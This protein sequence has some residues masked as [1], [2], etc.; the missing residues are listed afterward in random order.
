MNGL[1]NCSIVSNSAVDRRG[2]G[3]ARAPLKFGGLEKR[4]EKEICR[5][6]I[7]VRSRFKKDF[8]SGQKV[9]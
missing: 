4:I 9:S 3:C 2:A 7:T 8:G 5:Q 1:M 6:S